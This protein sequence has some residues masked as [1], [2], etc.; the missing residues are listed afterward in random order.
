[1][2]VS[3]VLFS[4]N[5]WRDS[6]DFVGGRPALMVHYVEPGSIGDGEKLRAMDLLLTVGNQ[7][8]R[9]LEELLTYLRAAESEKKKVVLKMVRVGNLD[10]SI[11]AYIERPLEVTDL[12][13]IGDSAL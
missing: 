12:R 7:P 11:F 6:R 2:L 9:T 4:G 8:V 5:P 3:G 13:V 1:V 10:D